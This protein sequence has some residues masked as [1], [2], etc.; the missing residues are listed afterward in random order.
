MLTAL[1][2][3]R[4]AYLAWQDARAEAEPLKIGTREALIWWRAENARQA[5]RAAAIDAG[6][7]FDA[8]TAD[9]ERAL[10]VLWRKR[11]YPWTQGVPVMARRCE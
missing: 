10:T 2:N 11:H 7:G 6:L 1:D 5:L 3:L 4:D 9:I 8:T